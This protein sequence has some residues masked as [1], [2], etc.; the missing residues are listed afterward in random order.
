MQGD[1]AMIITIAENDGE[2]RQVDSLGEARKIV[3]GRMKKIIGSDLDA[4]RLLLQHFTGK[5]SF[6]DLDAAECF[7]LSFLFLEENREMLKEELS[8]SGLEEIVPLLGP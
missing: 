7:D 8:T 2:E 5:G 3:W 4:A 1:E 6:H